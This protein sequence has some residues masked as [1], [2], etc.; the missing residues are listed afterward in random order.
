MIEFSIT[1]IRFGRALL[2]GIRDREFRRLLFFVLI[3]LLSGTIFYWQTEGW[4][5][6]D[7]LYFSVMTLTT[8]GNGDL[9]PQTT[10]GKVFTIIYVFTGVGVIIGFIHAVAH[11]VNQQSPIKRLMKDK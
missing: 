1:S 10:L 4:N 5:L 9:A 7:S 11:H 8:V 6:L 2:R 3:I